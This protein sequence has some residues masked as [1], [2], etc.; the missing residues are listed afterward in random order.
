V[1]VGLAGAFSPLPKVKTSADARALLAACGGNTRTGV[2]VDTWHFFRGD[3]EW[4]DLEA[5]PVDELAF[6]Q[7]SDGLP[8]GMDSGYDTLHRRA[9]PGDGEFDLDRFS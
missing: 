4:P 9:I 7:F 2:I 8:A 5:L 6:V 1:G 3:D